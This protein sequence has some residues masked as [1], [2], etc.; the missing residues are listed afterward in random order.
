[1][2]NGAYVRQDAYITGESNVSTRH[3]VRFKH[4]DITDN[5]GWSVWEWEHGMYMSPGV[6]YRT[7]ERYL[8]KPVYVKMVDCGN[9]P[10]NTTK[11]VAH[12]IA[13]IAIVVGAQA[14]ASNSTADFNGLVYMPVIYNGSLADRWTVYLAGVDAQ[15]IRIFCGGGLAGCPAYVTMRYTKTTQ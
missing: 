14:I 4:P 9:L 10:N 11:E 1:M 13:D 7:T 15:N 8:G 2:G 3:M 12:G 5:N 6:E